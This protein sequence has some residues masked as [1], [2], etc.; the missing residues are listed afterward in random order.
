MK[1]HHFASLIF[2][3]F[4]QISWGKV[5]GIRQTSNGWVFVITDTLNNEEYVCMAYAVRSTKDVC[6]ETADQLLAMTKKDDV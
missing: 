5:S 4:Q 6:P 2:Q 3:A 1:I